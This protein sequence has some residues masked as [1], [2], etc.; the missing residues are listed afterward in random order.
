MKLGALK[1]T[2]SGVLLTA[3]PLAPMF[4]TYQTVSALG[5]VFKDVNPCRTL[6]TQTTTPLL[7]QDSVKKKEKSVFNNSLISSI[8]F[9]SPT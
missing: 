4:Y 1:P 6:H 7:V 2:S 3:T 8:Y 5:Q 9:I